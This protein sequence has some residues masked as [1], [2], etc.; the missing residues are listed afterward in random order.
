MVV[1]KCAL[2]IGGGVGQWWWGT[3]AGSGHCRQ[4]EE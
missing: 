4:G 3:A 1:S 2:V